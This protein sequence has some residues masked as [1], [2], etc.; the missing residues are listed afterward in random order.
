MDLKGARGNGLCLL[1]GQPRVT[2]SPCSCFGGTGGGDFRNWGSGKEEGTDG[3]E[4]LGFGLQGW[5]RRE[6]GWDSRGKRM[7]L[8]A[9]TSHGDGNCTSAAKLPALSRWFL[10]FGTI[11]QL[12]SSPN[13]SSWLQLAASMAEGQMRGRTSLIRIQEGSLRHR[14]TLLR[15]MKCRHFC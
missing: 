2:T 12:G 6:R 15:W 10:N 14:E 5:R 8:L 4:A 13:S 7:M 11:L 1:V 3:L 9:N